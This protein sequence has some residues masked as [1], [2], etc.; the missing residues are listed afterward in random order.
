MGRKGGELASP[1]SLP[2][3]VAGSLGDA[4][5]VEVGAQ[6]GVVTEGKS[7]LQALCGKGSA[8]HASDAGLMTTW[9]SRPQSLA[10]LG[11]RRTKRLA[12]VAAPEGAGRASPQKR[13]CAVDAPQGHWAPRRGRARTGATPRRPLRCGARDTARAWRTVGRAVGNRPWREVSCVDVG[14]IRCRVPFRGGV[15]DRRAEW[16]AGQVSRGTPRPPHATARE[17]ASK[18]CYRKHCGIRTTCVAGSGLPITT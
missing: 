5:H 1:L 8:K 12:S 3:V 7:G 17:Y 18:G 9:Y 11:R 15:C 16:L 6:T 13:G 14:A 4:A 10:P 2:A